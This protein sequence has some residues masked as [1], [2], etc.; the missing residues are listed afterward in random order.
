MRKQFGFPRKQRGLG[1]IDALI[2]IILVA[3]GAAFYIYNG[4]MASGSQLSGNE[5]TQHAAWV[6][7]I[8]KA[9]NEQGDFAGLTS[10][11]LVDLGIVDRK[12][13]SGNAVMTGWNTGL[14]AVPANV[15]GAANDGFTFTVPMPRDACGSY[16]AA[17]ASAASIITVGGT[18]VLNGVTGDGKLNVAG[19]STA[20]N[21]SGGAGSVNVVI[22]ASRG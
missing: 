20:C 17:V 15:N 4:K 21:A 11:S 16:V 8:Q 3:G 7:R 19:T 2:G 13:L 5:A 10:K 9:F 18:S 22:S 6:G 1:V 12:R 14:V